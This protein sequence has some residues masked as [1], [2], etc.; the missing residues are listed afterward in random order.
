MKYS[1]QGSALLFVVCITSTCAVYMRSIIRNDYYSVQYARMRTEHVQDE[2][3]LYGFKKIAISLIADHYESLVQTLQEGGQRS[4]TLSWPLKDTY[5]AQVYIAKKNHIL[6]VAIERKKGV[7]GRLECT[8]QRIS[9]GS[10][11]RFYI[12]CL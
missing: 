5:R 1:Q 9:E 8:I 10:Q 7:L 4:I 6:T 11:V 12:T 2:Y 3:I